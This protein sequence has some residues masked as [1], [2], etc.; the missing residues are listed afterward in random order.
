MASSTINANSY[1]ATYHGHEETYLAEV[2]SRLRRGSDKSCIWLAGDSSLDNKFWFRDNAFAVNGYEAILAPPRM[3]QDVCYW[4]NALAKERNAPYFCVNTAVEATSLSDRSCNCLLSQDRFIRDN[5]TGEDILVVSV[6][7]NDIALAPLLCTIINI[8]PLVCCTP[9]FCLTPCG[10]GGSGSGGCAFS[11]VPNAM[12]DCGCLGCGLPGCL[13]GTLT[14]WPPGLGYFIDLFE[15]RVGNYV[16][17]LVGRRKPKKVLIN[18]IYFPDEVGTGSWADGALCCL[19]YNACPHRL[20]RAISTVYELGT[21]RIRIPGT[22]VVPVPLFSVLDPKDSSDYLQR[23][24]PSPQGGRKMAAYFLD[25][26]LDRDH[27][28]S[29][30]GDAAEDPLVDGGGGGGGGGGARG[31]RGA[32]GGGGGGGGGVGG[33]GGG[34]APCAAQRDDNAGGVLR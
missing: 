9:D 2:H 25:Q 8:I 19:G 4:V 22:Q 6:G 23:V 1:Y 16:R 21:K 17:R 29:S 34:G 20:Q 10:G 24:E 12:V 28:A 31:A 15:H 33:G 26:I 13:S 5:I 3:K 32:G 11:C 18:M 7:G 30:N 27:G 14:A